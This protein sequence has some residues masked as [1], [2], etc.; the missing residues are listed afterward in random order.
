MTK[1]DVPS[2]SELPYGVE[3]ETNLFEG[4][5][6][7]YSGSIRGAVVDP[8]IGYELVTHMLRNGA[9]VPSAHVAAR[10]KEEMQNVFY[11]MSGEGFDEDGNDIRTPEMAYRVDMKRWVDSA[12]H[13]VAVV[14]GPSHGVGME[15][16]RALLKPELGRNY[17]PVLC[18]VSEDNLSKISWM[19]TGAHDEFGDAIQVRTYKDTADAQRIVTEFLG[20][21][22][23][24]AQ[25]VK[26]V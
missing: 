4:R 9:E 8:M 7:Y 18:L 22:P 20:Q 12:T 26:E 13:I 14:D 19:I 15:I 10:N 5:R 24:D 2:S 6:V 23:D 1:L 25:S 21:V 17:T 11:Q 3:R 16:M